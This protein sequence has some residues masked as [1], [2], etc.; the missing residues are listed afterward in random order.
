MTN[1]TK[2]VQCKFTCTSI[3]KRKDYQS[4]ALI[5]DAEFQAVTRDSYRGRVF[6]D[7]ESFDAAMA[8]DETFWAYTPS[9]TIKV[10]TVKA[11]VFE[12]GKD[13]YVEFLTV[14]EGD[15]RG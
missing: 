11:D 10:G 1:T 13:Y 5:Y 8:E 14:A 2:R 12:V 6:T 9:G 3:T 7:R 4:T 15:G